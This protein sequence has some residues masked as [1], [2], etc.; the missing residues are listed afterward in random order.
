MNF[1]SNCLILNPPF[2]PLIIN[3]KSINMLSYCLV[4]IKCV[5]SYDYFAATDEPIDNSRYC[6]ADFHVETAT[7]LHGVAGY[8]EAVLYKEVN[9]S[10]YS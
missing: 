7:V 3:D 5:I 6:K 4:N 10:K 9:I 8:F 1:L 2:L